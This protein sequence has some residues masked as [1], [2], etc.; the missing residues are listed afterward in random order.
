[1]NSSSPLIESLLY[2][3]E[4]TALDFKRDQYPFSDA[5]DDQKSELLKDILAF[6]N[7][8][9][10]TDAYIVIGVKEGVTS[11]QCFYNSNRV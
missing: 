9:R 3:S 10:Q 8:F 7:S 6:A 4:G 11:T 2:Q 5:T 1:M